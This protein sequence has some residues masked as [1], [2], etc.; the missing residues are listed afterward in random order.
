[1]LRIIYVEDDADIRAMVELALEDEGFELFQYGSPQ[2]MLDQVDSVD[3]DL[4]L[5]DIMMPEIDGIT[6][7]RKLKSKPNLQQT[8][9]IFLTAKV[10]SAEIERYRACGAEAVIKKPFDVMEL[11]NQLREILQTHSSKSE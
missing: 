10:Q 5:L 8:P 9:I 3:P 4:I 1:M 11:A 7:A 6:V 2:Q